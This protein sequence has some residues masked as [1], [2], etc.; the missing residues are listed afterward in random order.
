MDHL[1]VKISFVIAMVILLCSPENGGSIPAPC[2]ISY[3]PRPIPT[4]HLK[5]YVVQDSNGLCDIDAIMFF[6]RNLKSEMVCANPNDGWVKKAIKTLSNKVNG[7][8]NRKKVNGQKNRKKVNGQK[9]RKKVNS[10][11]NRKKLN[12]QKKEDSFTEI[13][14]LNEI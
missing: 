6:T 10:Q 12:G 7:Q 4:Q 14:P 5:H 11:M 9:N 1:A 13:R 3:S 8:K 2:C